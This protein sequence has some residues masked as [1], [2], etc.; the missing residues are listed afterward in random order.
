MVLAVPERV[1]RLPRRRAVSHY[2]FI[3]TA[4]EALRTDLYLHEIG[5]VG[6]GHVGGDSSQV[7]YPMV[8]D[9]DAYRLGDRTG[10]WALGRQ[11]CANP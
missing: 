9:A 8:V 5:H 3:A 4:S 10:L 7:M 11:P 6:L 2:T 1:D